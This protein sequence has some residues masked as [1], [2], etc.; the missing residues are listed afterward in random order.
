LV[1]APLAIALEQEGKSS[2]ARE[3]LNHSKLRIQDWMDQAMDIDSINRKL[4]WF[5]L[6]EAIAVHREAT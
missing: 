6:A 1:D 5:N 2:E 3:L 4:P